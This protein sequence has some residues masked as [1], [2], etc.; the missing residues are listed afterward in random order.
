MLDKHLE[1]IP[2]IERLR[3]RVLPESLFCNNLTTDFEG[4]R[5]YSYEDWARELINHSDGF[6]KLTHGE[7]FEAPNSEAH[8]ECDAISTSYSIDF[9]LIL[10]QSLQR[11]VRETS[12]E[13]RKN[14]GMTVVCAGR[15]PK[16]QIGI[17]LH[18]VLRSFSK[19][20]LSDIADADETDVVDD[21]IKRD[22]KAFLK[23]IK[24]DKNL[25][26]IEPTYFFPCDGK[27]IAEDTINECLFRELHSAL[28]LLHDWYPARD[29]FIAYF[30]KGQMIILRDEMSQLARFDRV[31]VIESPTF[32]EIINQYDWPG[33][34]SDFL[35]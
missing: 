18:T 4:N 32:M 31:P 33:Y 19:E 24:H 30:I 3:S 8:G 26:L 28:S 25:L 6:M 15:S 16:E 2:G 21:P 12:Y 7:S 23:S 9:K 13:F 34:L 22:I 29:R 17:R 11:A 5:I 14:D 20:A 1:D 27:P 35:E 10:G